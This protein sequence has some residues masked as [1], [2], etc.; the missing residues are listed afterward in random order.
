MYM[1]YIFYCQLHFYS[2][3]YHFLS[4]LLIQFKSFCCLFKCLWVRKHILW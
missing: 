3:T 1:Y 4:I 2:P